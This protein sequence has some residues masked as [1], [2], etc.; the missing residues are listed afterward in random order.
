MWSTNCRVPGLVEGKY[1]T[2]GDSTDFV[3]MEPTT[4]QLLK[5]FSYF[6]SRIE[7]R[8]QSAFVPHDSTCQSHNHRCDRKANLVAAHARFDKQAVSRVMMQLSLT[9]V[10]N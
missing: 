8:A 2:G 6:I 5:T 7:A 1:V 3:L 10:G 9:L 4:V